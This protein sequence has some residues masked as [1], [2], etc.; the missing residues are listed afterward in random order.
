[1]KA[2]LPLLALAGVG[3]Y[4]LLRRRGPAEDVADDGA[5]TLGTVTWTYDG[6]GSPVRAFVAEARALAFDRLDRS[7]LVP[8]VAPGVLASYVTDLQPR[9]WAD[10]KGALQVLEDHYDAG[11]SVLSQLDIFDPFTRAKV[12][13]VDQPTMLKL[14]APGGGWAVLNSPSV[15]KSPSNPKR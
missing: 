6:L 12:V 13:V 9:G 7:R 2:V 8:T 5:R 14:A 15:P 3:G 10:G 4:V 1:M 11:G